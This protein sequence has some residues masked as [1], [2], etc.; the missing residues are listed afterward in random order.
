MVKKLLSLIFVASLVKTATAQNFSLSYQFSSVLSGSATTG[1]VDPTPTPTAAGVTSGSWT[2]VG[3]GTTSSGNAYFSFTGWGTGSAPGGTLAPS[4]FTGA[5]DLGKYYELTLSSQPNYMI[6]LTNMSFGASRSGTGVRNWAVRTN[7]D[8]YT[9]NIAATY[10]ALNAAATASSAPLITIDGSNVFLWK[11]DA[12]STSVSGAGF[13]NNNICNV[14]FSGPNYT[15]QAGSYIIRVYAWNAE[16]TGGTF[17]MDSTVI[18]GI[19][20]FSI[21]VGLNKVSHDL[22]AKIKLY[23]NPS[24]GEQ[25]FIEA[26]QTNVSAIELYDITGSLITKQ[27]V[28]MNE[29][30]VR[31]DLKNLPTGQYFVKIISAEGIHT[32]KLIISK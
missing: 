23:P 28:A 26:L 29:E 16:G 3:T 17:R 1:P 13:A 14:N 2:T 9:A 20:T 8:N 32:E 10:T 4:S 24:S 21:G 25:A 19:A 27:N 6:T 7:K 18:N 30:K 5:I 12:Y 11:D 22:N 31:I 15:D